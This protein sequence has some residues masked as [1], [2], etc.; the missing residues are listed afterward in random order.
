MHELRVNQRMQLGTYCYFYRGAGS[1]LPH[2]MV[3]TISMQ[4]PTFTYS[5]LVVTKD[6]KRMLYKAS[7]RAAGAAGF[8]LCVSS[9]AVGVAEAC[10]PHWPEVVANDQRRLSERFSVFHQFRGATNT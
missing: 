1:F 6:W 10:P 7:S 5:G 2:F 4:V 9:H 3:L 8:G